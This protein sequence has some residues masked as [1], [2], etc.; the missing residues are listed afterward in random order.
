MK[1]LGEI[2]NIAIAL[3][4]FQSLCPTIKH[5]KDGYFKR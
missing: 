5:G 4:K 1:E 2:K 3:G